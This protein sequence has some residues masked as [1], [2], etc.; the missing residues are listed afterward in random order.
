MHPLTDRH[1]PEAW[2]PN[3]YFRTTQ[4]MID[5]LPYLTDEEKYEYVIENTNKIADMVDGTFHVVHDKLFTPHIDNADENLRKLCFDNAHKQYGEVLPEIVEKRL[6]KELDNIIKHGFGVI[7]YIV[8]N[9][10]RNQ[11]KLGIL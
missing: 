9:W 7:Y 5:S 2:T 8:I 3:E 4:E 6:T 10:L 1:N 11:M